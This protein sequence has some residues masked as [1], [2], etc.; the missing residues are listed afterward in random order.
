MC[1]GVTVKIV[2]VNRVELVNNFL[3]ISRL[4]YLFKVF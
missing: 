2:P 3:V 1:H 4:N